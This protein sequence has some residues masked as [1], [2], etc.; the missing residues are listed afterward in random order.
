MEEWRKN[1]VPVP[2]CRIFSQFFLNLRQYGLEEWKKKSGPTY[3]IFS[4]S[5][6]ILDNMEEW[7][8]NR[9]PTYRI[10]SPSF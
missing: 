1:P 2:T 8:K 10:L 4:H 9:V 5:F 7:Q 6:Q 3:R